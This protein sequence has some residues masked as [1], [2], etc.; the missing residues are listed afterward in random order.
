MILE[1]ATA[2]YMKSNPYYYT[3]NTRHMK[4]TYL[5]L[6]VFSVFTTIVGGKCH[7]ESDEPQLP[8]ETTTGAMTF[9]CKVNGKVFVPRDGR[10]KPGLF[11]EYVYRGTAAGG[12]WHLN[13]PAINW[14]SSPIE[15]VSITTDSLLMYE[16]INYEFKTEKGNAQT[17]Y[18]KE[19]EY[20]KLN[21]ENGEIHIIK[22]D[23]QNRILSG[24]FFFTGTN[25][26]SGQKISVTDGRFDIRY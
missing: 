23:Q 16:G 1:T 3:Y 9:G 6:L 17:F 25:Q 5:L 15:G 10:G 13:I 24:T 21:Q 2:I 22:H 18:S 19:I 14:T 4:H 12:G 7:K 8:P 11:C 20:W 26:S